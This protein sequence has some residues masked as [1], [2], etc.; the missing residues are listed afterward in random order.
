MALEKAIA[1]H[2]LVEIAGHTLRI[3]HIS[4][5]DKQQAATSRLIAQFYS[6]VDASGV[7]LCPISTLIE[8]V[9][10][11]LLAEGI[12]FNY[13]Q[14]ES[15]LTELQRRHS[16]EIRFHVDRRGQLA[17]IKISPEVINSLLL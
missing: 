4:W 11:R 13:S 6:Q 3:P 9:Q 10:I 17:Y 8:A 15:L 16:K 2:S 1:S 5:D 7:A 12:L 14:A